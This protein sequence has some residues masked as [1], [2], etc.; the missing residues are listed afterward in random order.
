MTTGRTNRYGVKARNCRYGPIFCTICW[1]V[2]ISA[3][4]LFAAGDYNL[5]FSTTSEAGRRG[6]SLDYQVQASITQ[7]QGGV[8]QSTDYVVYPHLPG[9][10]YTPVEMQITAAPATITEN[11]TK[12]LAATQVM[13]DATTLPLP[14]AEVTWDAISGPIT[15]I[16]AAGVAQAGT[17]Y[18]N[19]AA[20]VQGSASGI[21]GTQNL[22]VLDSI[23]DNF[24][25]YAGDGL[26]DGWQ[27]QTMGVSGTSGGP[28]LDPDGDGLSN[29]MEYALGLD[30]VLRSTLLANAALNAGN[31]EYIY[32]RSKTA[33]TGGIQFQVQWSETLEAS[34]W[35]GS[36]VT[37]QVLS[38]DG[39]T[40]QV[41]ATLPAG[42]GGRRFVRLRVQ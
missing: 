25:N 23:P 38:D 37:E 20:S 15:G 17:V 8:L 14:A 18:Q 4:S 2:S 32:T 13:D 11:G 1:A 28:S 41:K 31:L 29:L 12:Q 9:Q 42:S 30:P 19:T 35:S 39:T 27:V 5:A 34:S 3:A 16:S 21:T 24:G 33:F 7:G 10:L 26:P 22:T 6:T 40:Q 36:N